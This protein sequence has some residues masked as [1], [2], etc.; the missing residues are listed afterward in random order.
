MAVSVITERMATSS[1]QEAGSV[2]PSTGNLGSMVEMISVQ[3]LSDL[4]GT[5]NF[6]VVD[7]RDEHEWSAGHI[8][9]ARPLPLDQLR[10]DPDAAL[11]QKDG[12]IFVCAKG[13]RSMTA[14]KLAQ[15]LGYTTIYSLDGGTNA[16]MRS[17]HELV[18]E[19][20]A[21]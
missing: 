1:L 18:V 21:A 13:V 8:P 11:P 4:L 12:L 10:S 20:R 3:K 17:G 19:R 14:A 7:V 16:W 9:G 6:D 5:G 15:R 2:R